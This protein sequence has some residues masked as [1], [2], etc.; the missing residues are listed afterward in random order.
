MKQKSEVTTV[1]ISP[2]IDRETSKAVQWHLKSRKTK[3]TPPRVVNGPTL[4]TGVCFC[5]K[6]GSAMKLKTGKYG[7]YRYYIYSI[8]ER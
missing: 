8:K 1:A 2:L 3:V 6:C 4:L 7:Q 5:D